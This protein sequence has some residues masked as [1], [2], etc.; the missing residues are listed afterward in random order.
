MVRGL[1]YFREYFKDFQGS[2]ILIGGVACDLAMEQAGLGFRATKDLD[3]VLCAEAINEEFVSKFWEFAKEGG[4]EHQEKSTGNKQFYRFNKPA[5]DQFPFMLELFSRKLDDMKLEDDS[6]LTPIPVDAD[7]L[8]LSA[9][10]L[11]DDYY[12]CIEKGKTV[13]DGVSVLGAEYILPF[14]ARAWLDLTKRRDSGK[15]VDSKDIK[16]HR[17]DVFRVFPLLSPNQRVV[18]PESIKTDM[19]DFVTAMPDEENLNMKDLG[20]NTLT[21]AVV[22]SSLSNIYD[23]GVN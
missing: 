3:I 17:N 6:H 10:L 16:K 2:Y 1:D 22:I 8:S 5:S 12:Q 19:R 20:I 7:V 21:L 13:I 4:Y 14:K 23:L 18:I 15:R 11:D 9:I